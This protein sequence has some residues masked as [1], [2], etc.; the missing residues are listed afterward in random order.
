MYAWK[1]QIEQGLSI[2]ISF[3]SILNITISRQFQDQ[4]GN[5]N[6]SSHWLLL[7]KKTH[8]LLRFIIKEFPQNEN[9]WYWHSNA[10]LIFHITTHS[11]VRKM[12]NI[13][14][15]KTFENICIWTS[16]IVHLSIIIRYLSRSK[17][18]ELKCECERRSYDSF[19]V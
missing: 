17:L 11:F 15:I 19:C 7:I 13:W 6:F 16:I 18:D 3:K 2:Y 14:C 8:K 5:N 1:W 10:C 9:H 12:P 4:C